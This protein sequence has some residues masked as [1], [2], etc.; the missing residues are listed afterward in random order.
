MRR[1]DRKI[2]LWLRD[3]GGV[4][5]R[6]GCLPRVTEV[7]RLEVFR[8]R[9]RI[10][11]PV[12]DERPETC[13]EIA[14]ANWTAQPA[15]H[16]YLKRHIDQNGYPACAMA[17]LGHIL[18]R[19]MVR[20]GQRYRKLDWLRAW[21]EITGGR[22]GIALDVALR[23]A[24]SPGFPIEGEESLR[25]HV[26]EAWDIPSIAAAGGAMQRGY[27]VHIGHD[28]HAEVACRIVRKGSSVAR[29]TMEVLNSWASETWHEEPVSLIDL[30]YGCFCPRAVEVFKEDLAA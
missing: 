7:G 17:S 15:L 9:Q 6:T 4:W 5:R 24:F 14:F 30:N 28:G 12:W 22:G 11:V 18:E 26:T 13:P 20:N 29:S 19:L 16:E 21:R 10:T 2:G 1:S 3:K 25:V 27:E 23:Y 8:R